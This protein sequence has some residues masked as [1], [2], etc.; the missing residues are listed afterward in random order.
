MLHRWLTVVLTPSMSAQ[1]T[2]GMRTGARLNVL[3]AVVFLVGVVGSAYHSVGKRPSATQVPTEQDETA[4]VGRTEC[5]RNLCPDKLY[6]KVSPAVVRAVA[7]NHDFRVTGLGSG[8]VVRPNGVIVTNHHV[9][10]DAYFVDVQFPSGISYLVDAVIGL[11]LDADLALLRV[12]DT[13]LPTLE[14][15]EGLLPPIGTQVFAIGN[16]LGLTNSLSEGV[17]SGHRTTNGGLSELQTTAAISAGSSGG[18]LLNSAGEVVG[19][20]T[21]SLEG[22]QNL[23]FAVPVARVSRLLRERGTIK[24]LSSSNV[25]RLS[26]TDASTLEQVWQA[27]ES[28]SYH[29]ALTLLGTLRAGQRQSVYYWAAVGYVHFEL[30][31]NELAVEAYKTALGIAP[32]WPDNYFNLGLAYGRCGQ[33]E[34]AVSAFRSAAALDPGNPEILYTLGLTL[35]E[36]GRLTEAIEALRPASRLTSDNVEILRSLGMA[37]ALADQPAEA[38]RSLEWAVLHGARDATTLWMLGVSYRCLGRYA[39]AVS[40]LELALDADRHHAAARC[41]LG[42]VYVRV[43]R[44]WDAI[45]ALEMALRQEPS[46]A[47]SHLFLGLAYWETDQVEPA[48]EHLRWAAQ[49][50]PSGE[51]GRK[52]SALL[53]PILSLLHDGLTPREIRASTPRR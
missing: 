52:A 43:G 49:L 53:E 32:H 19:V 11:D 9:V 22:G 15:A 45:A 36:M 29:R 26:G 41:A 31:N 12:D 46:S 18:P 4:P 7:R 37:Y 40:S 16:P 20:T 34:A 51:T 2:S 21:Q 44:Y 28:S 13:N 6:A 33:R 47:Q 3:L 30:G 17:V 5:P 14:M 38:A 25:G 24:T 8:F 10:A 1:G 23:N 42:A 27:I 35:T 39:D 50:D 48:L